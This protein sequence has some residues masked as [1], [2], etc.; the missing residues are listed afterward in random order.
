MRERCQPLGLSFIACLV[1][2]FGA[3]I[4]LSL[5]ENMLAMLAIL[6]PFNV[7]YSLFHVG[8]IFTFNRL[9]ADYCQRAGQ[10]FFR[11][12]FPCFKP[13][14]CPGTLSHCHWRLAFRNVPL[15]CRF[16]LPETNLPFLFCP[17]AFVYRGCGLLYNYHV[18]TFGLCP[19]FLPL[20]CGVPC[21]SGEGRRVSPFRRAHC[22]IGVTHC[23]QKNYYKQ[24]PYI[25]RLSGTF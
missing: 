19:S 10:P 22:S 1:S 20:P 5:L 7:L 9:S 13:L 14:P 18:L 2:T 24:K 25:S 12:R 21:S 17:F 11:L 23:Q 8:R 16:T 15:S 6:F 3:V 4:K